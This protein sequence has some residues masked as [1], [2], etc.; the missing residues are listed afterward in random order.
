ME[1]QRHHHYGI[2]FLIGLLI[3]AGFVRYQAPRVQALTDV[4]IT[5]DN[6]GDNDNSSNE[7][8]CGGDGSCTLRTAIQGILKK[9]IQ[10][11][12]FTSDHYRF[13]IQ[14]SPSVAAVGLSG[15]TPGDLPDIR[16][17]TDFSEPPYPPNPCAGCVIEIDGQL[18]RPA[19]TPIKIVGD[20]PNGFTISDPTHL[21]TIK[22]VKLE[23]FTDSAVLIKDNAMGHEIRDNTFGSLGSS[24]EFS[25]PNTTAIKVSNAAHAKI[26]GNLIGGETSDAIVLTG[27][28]TFDTLVAE[29]YIGVDP[30]NI[31]NALPTVAGNGVLIENGAHDN[32]IKGGSEKNV[33]AHTGQNG[34]LILNGNKNTVEE[35]NVFFDNNNLAIDLDT[36]N[37]NI[38]K[39][40]L[41][42]ALD[43]GT[44]IKVKGTGVGGAQINFYR[45]NNAFNPTVVP[46]VSGG[47]GFFSLQNNIIDGGGDL[48]SD[49]DQ[50]EFVLSGAALGETITSFQTS[51]QNSSEFSN[52]VT[53]SNAPSNLPP[54]VSP[55]ATPSN[56]GPGN[57]VTLNANGNDPNGDSLTFSWI[58]TTGPAIT[59]NPNTTSNPVTFVV[60]TIVSPTTFTFSVTANDGVASATGTVTVN[61]VPGPGPTPTPTPTPT[62]SNQAP[63]A[64]AGPDQTVSQGGNVLLNGSGSSDP[65]GDALTYQ[66]TQ[67]GSDPY[68]VILTNQNTVTPN[69]SAP[70]ITELSVDLH[71]TLQVTDPAN[72]TASDSVTIK[73]DRT[74][75]KPIAKLKVFPSNTVLPGTQVRLSGIQST[76]DPTANTRKYTFRQITN[77]S[78]DI[79]L[80]VTQTNDTTPEASVLMPSGITTAT[81]FTFEL[82]VNDGTQNS[83]PDTEIVTVSPQAPST[84]AVCSTT[85]PNADAGDNLDENK[86]PGEIIT[87]SGIRS[88]D[89]DNNQ[90]LSY[91][92]R[93][94]AGG[95][96]VD[97]RNNQSAQPNF[98]VPALTTASITMEFE[99]T[100]TD[101]CGLSDTDNVRITL[102][103]SDPDN[104]GID[105]T[106]EAELHTDPENPDT[107]GDGVPDGTEARSG[108]MSPLNPDSDN[109]GLRDGEE[110]TN[111]NGI[112]EI[113]ET[114]PGNADTDG[115]TMPDGFEIRNQLNPNNP[116]DAAEDSDRDGLLNREEFI[117][118]TNPRVVDSDGDGINDTNE[119]KGANRTSPNDSDS[120][121]D[122][123]NDGNEDINHDGTTQTNE[124]SPVRFD[125]DFDGLSD[126]QEIGLAQPQSKGT[127][128]KK[129]KADSD[130][131]SK[132][133]P[134]T[135]D[136]DAD[137][138]TD[139][140][141]DKN[142]NGSFDCGE[143]SPLDP[144]NP[145]KV[146][147]QPTPTP[148]PTKT[149][150]AQSTPSSSINVSKGS[151]V[152]TH[153]PT[154]TIVPGAS[155]TV[156]GV[157]KQT[158]GS[159]SSF[160][161]NPQASIVVLPGIL[162]TVGPGPLL[163]SI[164]V[165]AANTMA[166]VMK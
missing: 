9:S 60:P 57:T 18:G 68:L 84:P 83:D 116:S 137:K 124:T 71:F 150:R 119:A 63:I 43:N 62:P 59:I 51:S 1:L 99:L 4:V 32:L 153:V 90:P 6:A 61:A 52:N 164:M 73:I 106:R 154:V 53:V 3:F 108:S 88:S 10:I 46:D 26:V 87:L 142:K 115:D 65:N 48:D 35:D 25:T 107:D 133:G 22:N 7:F 81:E 2:G 151:P 76:F 44:N 129:F 97:I 117:F 69:F 34:I 101:S 74:I 67:S 56:P 162:A 121:D 109:D 132:T 21:V 159:S 82:V 111:R 156:Q 136:T 110:D 145:P 118:K 29:N 95:V 122:G 148:T 38:N 91:F 78:S 77:S 92:W 47:E 19:L 141:E 64:N 94:Q 126:G 158:R 166:Q 66:W 128:T 13:V 55:T 14:F 89:P 112:A 70:N 155:I 120:D 139:G 24:D 96:R 144:A 50:F 123:I 147:V 152:A 39:P 127:D 41:T 160:T 31:G 80:V 161:A 37:D 75:Q 40:T 131:L 8:F 146:C 15:G 30:S 54:T 72:L 98:T 134:L 93:Q 130:P 11:T 140:N 27:S 49:P 20:S 100:V 135:T 16:F 42:S 103:N 36:A 28:S 5:V 138:I 17:R 165:F 163:P 114:N 86:V 125:S 157:N 104:D 85:A 149:S 105:N 143:T 79:P 33:I 45:A 23:N 113:G 12:D 102:R 58:Q